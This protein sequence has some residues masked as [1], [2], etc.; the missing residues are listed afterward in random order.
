[1]KYWYMLHHEWT[2]QTSC[3][4]KEARQKM[5][6]VEWY[7]LYEIPTLVTIDKSIE[8]EERLVAAKDWGRERWGESANGQYFPWSDGSV[9]QL[10]GGRGFHNIVYQ[11]PSNHSL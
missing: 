8:E 1:M 6:R 9:L 4:V 3:Y 2:S 7:Y 11:M 10:N 5:F